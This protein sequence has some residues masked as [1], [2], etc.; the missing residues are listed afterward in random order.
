VK[1]VHLVG[2]II[3]KFVAMQNGHKKA[4][5]F[6]THPS[7]TATV[8]F[9]LVIQGSRPAKLEKADILEMAVQHLQRLHEQQ[10]RHQ[11]HR[12]KQVATRESGDTV[13]LTQQEKRQAHMWLE[14]CMTT[15]EDQVKHEEEECDAPKQCKPS[16]IV[17]DTMHRYQKES[18]QT[19]T[20]TTAV[21][22]VS[23]CMQE[24]CYEDISSSKFRAGFS[25]CAREAWQFLNHSEDVHIAV[26]ERL[27]KHLASRL[28]ALEDREDV[29]SSSHQPADSTQNTVPETARVLSSA[30]P[31]VL[32]QTPSGFTLL[33]TKLANGDLIFVIPADVTKSVTAC[34]NG[35]S[36]SKYHANSEVHGAEGSTHAQDGVV[37]R[38]W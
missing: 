34:L 27:S 1:L 8:L 15:N 36:S 37:W 20:T 23:S 35:Q 31:P 3:K 17:S 13:S 16:P 25:E 11:E 5:T 24:I 33:P 14:S 7:C 19:T 18:A 30:S 6:P 9:F 10:K 32:I 4:K 22:N 29:T 12:L 2:F 26:R 21:Q 38:P 28:D